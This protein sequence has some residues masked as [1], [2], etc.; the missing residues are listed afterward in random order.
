MGESIPEPFNL[1]SIVA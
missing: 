1:L